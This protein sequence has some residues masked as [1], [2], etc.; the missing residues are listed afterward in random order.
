MHMTGWWWC[1]QSQA[2]P[3]RWIYLVE[4][5]RDSFLTS[6]LKLFRKYLK[7]SNACNL[8]PFLRNCISS[9]DLQ[10]IWLV[11]YANALKIKAYL[12][13]TRKSCRFTKWCEFIKLMLWMKIY[14][15]RRK[16]LLLEQLAST[17]SEKQQNEVH[18]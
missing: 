13:K 18:V 10:L 7:I 11:T 1:Q 6:S 12:I 17:D 4:S 15:V 8:Q 14:F 16:S 5:K 9:N 2:S 3:L